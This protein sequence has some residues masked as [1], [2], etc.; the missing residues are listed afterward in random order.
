VTGRTIFNLTVIVRSVYSAKQ[1]GYRGVLTE[2]RVYSAQYSRVFFIN[3]WLLAFKSVSSQTWQFDGEASDGK[4]GETLRFKVVLPRMVWQ[5][6]SYVC[7]SVSRRVC[8]T[9]E[10]VAMIRLRTACMWHVGS[11]RG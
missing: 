10:F 7:L 6:K 5:S 9:G 11:L 8:S 3:Y 4:R 2:L 1:T